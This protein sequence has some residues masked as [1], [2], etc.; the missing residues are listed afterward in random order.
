MIKFYGSP[1]CVHCRQFRANLDSNRLN[2]EYIDIDSSILKLREFLR[3]RDTRHEFD[4]AK[5]EGRV[6]VPAIVYEDGSISLDWRAYLKSK[7]VENIVSEQD[8]AA[9][10]SCNIDGSGC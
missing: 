10:M 4:E 9:K 8:A 5:C 2:Y 7:G 6:G 1:N 3:L